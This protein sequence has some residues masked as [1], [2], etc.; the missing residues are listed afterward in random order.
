MLWR[1]KKKKTKNK[2]NKYFVYY[3][4]AFDNAVDL[5]QNN[6]VSKERR[7]DEMKDIIEDT[8]FTYMTEQIVNRMVRITSCLDEFESR[9]KS[10]KNFIKRNEINDKYEVIYFYIRKR[11]KKLN[12]LAK[13]I[14]FEKENTVQE[15][16]RVY[17]THMKNL[18]L[19]LEGEKNG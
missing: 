7:C 2:D 1:K 19:G 17:N 6:N 13:M 18:E 11:M 5:L 14:N 4:T 8:D 16:E 3:P 15:I 10:L 12:K 9:Y